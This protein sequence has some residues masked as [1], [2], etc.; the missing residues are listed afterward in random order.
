MRFDFELCFVREVVRRS[1]NYLG[2]CSQSKCTQPSKNHTLWYIHTTP[3]TITLAYSK[4]SE[5]N[6]TRKEAWYRW[7]TIKLTTQSPTPASPKG[8]QT[9]DLSVF[10]CLSVCLF[11]MGPKPV[12]TS[13]SSAML[14]LL[15]KLKSE[16][17]LGLS[18]G[19]VCSPTSPP[20]PLPPLPIL[21]A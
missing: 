18:S 14:V 4:R 5:S 12:P 17:L 10:V 16:L 20:P 9:I 19:S 11:C 8:K 21:P 7:C 1:T 3:S 2:S 15:P 6:K 13:S